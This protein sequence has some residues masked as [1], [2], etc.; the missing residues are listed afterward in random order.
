MKKLICLISAVLALCLCFTG[1]GG[2]QVKEPEP[3]TV[4][5]GATPD[6][7]A[8]KNNL[9]LLST[10][11]PVAQLQGIKREHYENGGYYYV[12][13]TEDK[14]LRCVSSCYPNSIKY[15]ET[16]EAYAQRR[17]VGLSMSVTPGNPTEITAVK[18]DN[19]TDV[20]GAPVYLVTYLTGSQE[21]P[22]RW[23]VY[24]TRNENYSFQYAF[25][26]SSDADA[27]LDKQIMNYFHTLKLETMA[28]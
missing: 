18:N 20:L 27:K 3:T 15:D 25:C 8:T 28:K 1:C 21:T 7:A 13:M 4:L 23:T 24:L 22:V 5:T 26:A 6:E 14:S 11:K 19:L 9:M 12:D 10:A 2:N 16:E 17:A